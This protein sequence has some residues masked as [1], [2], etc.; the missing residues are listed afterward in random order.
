VARQRQIVYNLGR[1]GYDASIAKEL[2]QQFEQ[3]LE[4][5]I[6]DRDRI[7]LEL[8]KAIAHLRAQVDS[9][10]PAAAV[11]PRSQ[12]TEAGQRSGG[13]AERRSQAMPIVGIREEYG[14]QL[15]TSSA[16]GM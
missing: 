1:R 4:L 13:T 5:Y 14:K 9:R 16:V 10:V 12:R 3:T 11:T 8:E 7:R 6:A 2:L 15:P